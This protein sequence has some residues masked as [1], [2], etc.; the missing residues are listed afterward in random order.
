MMQVFIPT[1]FLLINRE[2]NNFLFFLS[3]ELTAVPKCGM[4]EEQWWSH[5]PWEYLKRVDVALGDVI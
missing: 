3:S 5:Y 4:G 2:H 1:L